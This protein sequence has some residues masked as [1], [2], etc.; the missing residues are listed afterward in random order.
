MTLSEIAETLRELRVSPVKSLGQNFLHDRNIARWI[1]QQLNPDKDDFVLEIGPG[2]G[3]LTELVASQVG[4]ILALE[5]DGRLAAFLRENF[6][7]EGVEIRHQDAMEFDVR[8]LYAKPRVKLLGN[9]PYYISSQL[10]L[11]FLEFPSPISL[12]VLMLQKEMAE[13]ITAVPGTKDYGAFTL[14]VQYDYTVEFLRTVPPSVFIPQPEVDSA[15]VRLIPRDPQELP[16]C[17]RETFR[18]LVRTGFSQRRKQLGKLLRGDM[19]DWA[20]TAAALGLDSAVR[21]ERLSLQDWIALANQVRPAR[22]EMSGPVADEMFA[23]V[24]EQD[25]VIG[26]APRRQ[27][28]GN[29]L[30]HRAV[31]ILLFNPKG[32]VYLQKRSRWKDRHPFLWDS[33]AA[34]HVAAGEDYDEAAER[35][36]REELDVSTSLSR[37]AQ[38]PA[39]EKTGQEFIWVYTGSSNKP[40]RTDP[41]ETEAGNYFPAS[42]V[43]DWTQVRPRDFAPGFVEC[44][45][46]WLSHRR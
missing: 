9:L 35:E 20:A 10:L 37:L 40:V 45:K 3:A 14:M 39:S 36:L 5:K 17:D 7:S 42:V 30:R 13:R 12:A 46:A 2:L 22:P 8:T 28:H 16:P 11:R 4:A 27:V 1:T 43:R 23:V 25:R 21:A 19:P 31:H 29:N 34:G 24:D 15:V 6:G 38:L 26:A 18:K 41:T 32:E 44:W 33:S